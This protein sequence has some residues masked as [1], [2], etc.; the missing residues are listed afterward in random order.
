MG[1][2]DF[3]IPGL[4][5]LGSQVKKDP[6]TA[7]LPVAGA[8][9]NRGEKQTTTPNLTPEMKALREAITGEASKMAD[10]NG[11]YAGQVSD[12]NHTRDL[13][14]QQLM[15]NFAQRGVTGPAYDAAVGHVDDQRFSDVIKAKQQ[16]PLLR[17]QLL[18]SSAGILNSLPVGS[19]QSAPGNKLGGAFTELGRYLAT[20]HGINA[21]AKGFG[22]APKA[23]ATTV[24]SPA[25]PAAASSSMPDLNEIL[26]HIAPLLSFKQA[27][28]G[29][30][31]S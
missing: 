5:A 14:K 22:G 17:A 25:T 7:I 4:Q 26:A 9:A 28:G 21:A 15:E 13:Q 6:L 27:Y 16:L 12:I 19:T 31:G 8:L 10:V 18:G 29:G 1:L 24:P 23:A 11:I 30:N 2:F 3:L 20:I